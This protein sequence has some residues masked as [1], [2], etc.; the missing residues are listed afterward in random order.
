MSS[1]RASERTL[2]ADHGVDVD[3]G[4]DCG[5]D[6]GGELLHGAEGSAGG[7][8]FVVVDVAEGGVEDGA[9]AGSA[10][11]PMTSV[12]RARIQALAWSPD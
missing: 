1:R 11:D 3:G 5:S 9:E 10:A 12:T 2:T 4:D 8:G 7:A 6:A